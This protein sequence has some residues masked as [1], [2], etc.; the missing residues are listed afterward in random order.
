MPA[1]SR[2]QMPSSRRAFLQP[3]EGEL[4]VLAGAQLASGVIGA[5]AEIAARPQAPYRHAIARLRNGIADPKLGEERFAVRFSSPKA[6]LRPNWRRKPRCQSTGERS[7]GARELR[8]LVRLGCRIWVS[9]L[10]F[11]RRTFRSAKVSRERLVGHLMP[12]CPKGRRYFLLSRNVGGTGA[13]EI[14][15]RHITAFT[16]VQLVLLQRPATQLC[17]RAPDIPFAAFLPCAPAL[18]PSHQHSRRREPRSSRYCCRRSRP[19]YW[20]NVPFTACE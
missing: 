9:A 12:L 1:G 5:R 15:N 8:F 3:G 17:S 14:D 19:T 18:G 10:G 6:C 11:H 16:I 7:V 13:R 4:D 20:A 2:A